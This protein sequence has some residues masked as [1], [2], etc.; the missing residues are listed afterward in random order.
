MRKNKVVIRR[1]T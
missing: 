1:P